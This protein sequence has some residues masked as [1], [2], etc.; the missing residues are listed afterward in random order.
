M[1]EIHGLCQEKKSD[2]SPRRKA[3]LFLSV[4]VDLFSQ[5]E[6]VWEDILTVCRMLYGHMGG[7][8]LRRKKKKF[9]TG[10]APQ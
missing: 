3:C 8:K 4:T 5:L 1:E 9:L 2:R 10:V 7:I 6:Q